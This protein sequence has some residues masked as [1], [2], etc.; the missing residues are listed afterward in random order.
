MW[1]TNM[2]YCLYRYVPINAKES[3]I[4]WEF[5]LTKY[6]NF[7]LETWYNCMGIFQLK[8]TKSKVMDLQT[9]L[10]LL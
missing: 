3:I 8:S 9:V 6:A 10:F 4:V 1:S 5:F 7:G 2:Q